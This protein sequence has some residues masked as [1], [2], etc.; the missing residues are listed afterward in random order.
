[1]VAQPTPAAL[2]CARR[3][4]WH[5][6][7]ATTA[8]KA[9]A[10]APPITKF[11]AP[12]AS[13]VSAQYAAAGNVEQG[14][15]HPQP[16]GDREGASIDVQKRHE[17]RERRDTRDHQEFDGET[18]RVVS[19]SI[20]SLPSIVAM[21]AAKLAPVRPASTMPVRMGV[22]SRTEATPTRSAT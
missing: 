12:R 4:K 9:A 18:P 16:A 1:V 15:G 19:A 10:L 5:P 13:R 3:P 8:P 11:A 21:R 17:Q 20:S 7:K 2:R 14:R 22:S 6:S